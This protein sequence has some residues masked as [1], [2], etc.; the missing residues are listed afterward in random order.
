MEPKE[1]KPK[2]MK[3]QSGGPQILVVRG[4]WISMKMVRRLSCTSQ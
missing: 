1:V 2:E 3:Y 4:R